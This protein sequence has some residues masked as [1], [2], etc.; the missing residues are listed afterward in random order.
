MQVLRLRYGFIGKLRVRTQRKNTENSSK[1]EKA[2]N[3]YYYYARTLWNSLT[4]Q[5]TKDWKDE[6]SHFDM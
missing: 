4:I 6:T 2:N 3:A 5:T 1:N